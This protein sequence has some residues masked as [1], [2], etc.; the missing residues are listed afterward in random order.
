MAD[1]PAIEA[2]IKNIT[3]PIT[4]GKPLIENA[5]IKISTPINWTTMLTTPT[6]LP[7]DRASQPLSGAV[8]SDPNPTGATIIPAMIALAPRTYSP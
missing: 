6:V 4:N 2:P 1:T 7:E 3:A 5:A 8:A